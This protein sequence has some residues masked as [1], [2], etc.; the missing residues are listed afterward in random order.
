MAGRQVAQIDQR[1]NPVYFALDEVGNQVAEIDAVGQT[2]YFGYD[3][4]GRRVS[5]SDPEGRVTYWQYSIG[6]NLT[7][8]EH[9]GDGAAYFAYDDASQPTAENCLAQ[10]GQ[11][12]AV[13]PRG[14]G[15]G[16]WR[17]ARRNRHPRPCNWPPG[18]AP[19]R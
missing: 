19:Y 13:T 6:G 12:S 11:P 14:L 1:G 9:A 18:V 7:R 5:R 15:C 2:T 8:R 17:P 3:L 10:N 16:L 4:A